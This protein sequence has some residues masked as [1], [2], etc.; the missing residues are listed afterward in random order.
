MSSKKRVYNLDNLFFTPF[1]MS[2]FWVKN[3]TMAKLDKEFMCSDE[4]INTYGFR[5]L[6]DG[7]KLERFLVNPVMLYMHDVRQVIGSWEELRNEDT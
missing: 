3:Y 4:S 7:G 2:H 5:V 6:T 1:F